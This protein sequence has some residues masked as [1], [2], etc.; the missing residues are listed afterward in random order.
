[1]LFSHF[2]ESQDN[3]IWKEAFKDVKLNDS[4]VNLTKVAQNPSLILQ[5]FTGTEQQPLAPTLIGNQCTDQPFE[6]IAK[7]K[8]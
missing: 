3:Q 8:V 1:M 6:T 4:N 7:D 5:D 2:G